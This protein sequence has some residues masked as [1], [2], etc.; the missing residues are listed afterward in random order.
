MDENTEFVN[1]ENEE[2]E[3]HVAEGTN[4]VSGAKASDLSH[5]ELTEVSDDDKNLT[6]ATQSEEEVGKD[7]G[8][9]STPEPQHSEKPLT[10]HESRPDS[11]EKGQ[12]MSAIKASRGERDQ[13]E[14][15][16]DPTMTDE[17]INPTLRALEES[18]QG[19]V[20]PIKHMVGLSE[21]KQEQVPKRGSRYLDRRGQ[22]GN[23]WS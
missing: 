2:M 21:E 19:L 8:Q 14:R 4:V 10:D 12:I 18:C 6:P 23:D 13:T 15:E 5:P 7:S 1:L 3:N 20:K 9:S 11:V 16:T 17:E 22:E